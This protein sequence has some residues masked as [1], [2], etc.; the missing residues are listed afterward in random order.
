MRTS[1]FRGLGVLQAFIG[2]GAVA[3]GLLL[4]VDPSGAML[5][6]PIELLDRTPFTTFLVPG[7][8]LFVVNGLGSMVGSVASFIRHR[9]AGELAMAL[10]VF[11]IMWI[12]VQV[13]WMAPHWLHALYF[14]LGI[15]EV[16]LGWS[17]W[18]SLRESGRAAT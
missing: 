15:L 18:K 2:V 5:G 8:V 3:G 6:T 10:G 4:V 12:A 1:L 14:G 9:C 11:L 13:Y 16:A 7:I 17:V